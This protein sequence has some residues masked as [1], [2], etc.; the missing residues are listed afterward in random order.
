MDKTVL[1]VDDEIEILEIM[2]FELEDAGFKV[3][4]AG[5]GNE[6]M[7]I[8][9][10]G[11][12]DFIISD[13][14]MKNGSG[15]DLIEDCRSKNLSTPILLISGFSDISE[16]DARAKGA[17]GIISKPMDFDKILSIIN[18]SN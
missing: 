7:K 15:L 8:I 2:S 3:I 9:E 17:V 11:N 18:Q 10:S 5:S 6:G 13:V 4:T 16:E 12:I 14:R 1:I